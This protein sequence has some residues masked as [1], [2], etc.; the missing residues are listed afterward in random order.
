MDNYTSLD[1]AYGT[2]MPQV[3]P[4]IDTLKRIATV[5]EKVDLEETIRDLRINSERE[6][7]IEKK[8]LESELTVI[9]KKLAKEQ[10][11][12]KAHL[13][14]QYAVEKERLLREHYSKI[15]SAQKDPT[16]LTAPPT[17]DNTC[18]VCMDEQKNCAFVPC[19]HL[20]VCFVCANEILE[21]NGKC[22]LCRTSIERILKI[23]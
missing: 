13:Q 4:T 20:T 9:K 7:A 1:I 10:A 8:K 16:V 22:P 21:Q 3:V 2:P 12:E 11:A 15:E 6:Q 14:Q 23:F 5:Q 19:G 18:S 17:N